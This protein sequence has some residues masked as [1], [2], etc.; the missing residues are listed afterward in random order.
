M[1]RVIGLLLI[2]VLLAAVGLVTF[3]YSGFLEPDRQSVTQPV[4]LGRD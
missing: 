2:L 1:G 3:S 4:D